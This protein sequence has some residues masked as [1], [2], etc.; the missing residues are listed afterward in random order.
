M[1]TSKKT[2]GMY[3]GDFM[4]GSKQG[5]G[6]EERSDGTNKYRGEFQ[7]GIRSGYG[8]YTFTNG[9]KYVGDF[10]HGKQ[11]GYGTKIQADGNV[12]YQGF[13]TNGKTDPELKRRDVRTIEYT[14]GTYIGEFTTE[15][16]GTVVAHG[17]GTFES[18]TNGVVKVYRGTFKNGKQHGYSIVTTTEV[19]AMRLIL[20]YIDGK[21]QPLM[22]LIP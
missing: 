13:W 20:Q 14:T 3:S 17:K 6:I 1:L 12:V 10:A 11:H 7:Y 2:G 8:E 19:P 4:W 22:K 15:K 9:S 16:D 18:N 5:W 21:S